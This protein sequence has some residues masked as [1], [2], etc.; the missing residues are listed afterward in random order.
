MGRKESDLG[1]RIYDNTE[2]QNSTPDVIWPSF[3]IL[4]K[5]V[6][7]KNPQ[8]KHPF[9]MRGFTNGFREEL[10]IKGVKGRRGQG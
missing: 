7:I 8:S 4:L 2:E 1:C 5:R 9:I 6:L 3:I 10:S